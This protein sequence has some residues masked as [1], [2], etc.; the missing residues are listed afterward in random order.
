[1]KHLFFT[2]TLILLFANSFSQDTSHV[3][4]RTPVYNEL[5]NEYYLEKAIVIDSLKPGAKL[6][7][8]FK[9][10]AYYSVEYNDKKQGFIPAKNISPFEKEIILIDSELTLSKTIKKA[11]NVLPSFAMHR[12]Y[13]GVTVLKRESDYS[14]VQ[15]KD[16][17]KGWVKNEFLIYVDEIPKSVEHV[18]IFQVLRSFNRFLNTHWTLSLLNFLLFWIVVLAIPCIACYYLMYIGLGKIRLIPNWL[19]IFLWIVLFTIT[20]LKLYNFLYEFPPF[21]NHLYFYLFAV[22]CCFLFTLKFGYTRIRYDRCP[23]CHKIH[24]GTIVD[25]Q[26]LSR[27]FYTTTKTTTYYRGGN[28]E[29]ETNEKNNTT[30]ITNKN[31][32]ACRFCGKH[33]SRTEHYK[34]NGHVSK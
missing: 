4:N 3:I 28:K 7:L 12:N 24:A 1:M 10:G 14:L 27:D 17:T 21:S 19:L 30:E 29:F 13:I 25:S 32:L 20:F 22:V 11:S 31:V 5:P 16:S 34:V 6:I 33:W 18:Q 8:N 9:Q 23:H 26:E 2:A 15:K